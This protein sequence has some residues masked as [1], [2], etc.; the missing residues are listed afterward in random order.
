MERTEEAIEIHTYCDIRYRD[1][2]AYWKLD[3]AV[4]IRQ[5]I[6]LAQHLK[7]AGNSDVEL[8]TVEGAPHNVFGYALDENLSRLKAFFTRT[9]C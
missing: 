7:E 6:D 1:G 9:L 5:S 8:I 4:P 3:L 2:N